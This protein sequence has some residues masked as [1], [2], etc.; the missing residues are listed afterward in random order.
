MVKTPERSDGSV[1][2][3]AITYSSELMTLRIYEV[4]FVRWRPVRWIRS[5]DACQQ[6][7]LPRVDAQNPCGGWRELS[8]PNT[9]VHT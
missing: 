9:H 8:G 3:S 5:K 6:A 4:K 2:A 1:E 7:R